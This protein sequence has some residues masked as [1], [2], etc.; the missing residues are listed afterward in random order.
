MPISGNQ[1]ATLAA[2]WVAVI[3]AF[4]AL[5]DYNPAKTTA[6]YSMFQDIHV[7]IF[8]GFGFLMSF[9]VQGSFTSTGHSLLVAMFA[10]VFNIINQWVW[11]RVINGS[12]ASGFSI[13]V[14]SLVDADFAAG[15]VLI[16]FG[17]LIGRVSL[18][19]LVVMAAVEVVFYNINAAVCYGRLAVA[20]IGGSMVIHTFGAYFGLTVSLMLDRTTSRKEKRA[21]KWSSDHNSD[22][23]AMIGTLFLWC[24]WPSFNAYFAGIVENGGV[25]ER[26]VVNTYLS[27]CGSVAATFIASAYFGN[28]KL[29]IVDVQNATL[30]GGVAIGA[31]S[32]MLTMPGGALIVGTVAG[33]LSTF[34]Y[35]VLQP[36]LERKIGLADTCGVHNLHG[37][38]GLLGAFVSIIMS[39]QAD[40]SSYTKSG[41]SWTTVWPDA[42]R[43][44]YTSMALVGL[45]FSS[46]FMTVGLAVGGGVVAAF[47]LR[48]V[49]DL[50]VFYQDSDEYVVEEGHE[51][52]AHGDEEMTKRIESNSE[53]PRGEHNA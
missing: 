1:I 3:V 13:G 31:A 25:G 2:I 49:P 51:E 43:N 14:D 32:N 29:S 22:T 40:S 21:S 53:S 7:M 4:L 38:P 47:I 34:G 33:T 39:S 20:D 17:A 45:Q 50:D 16:S 44:S 42:D 26:V 24:F 48:F 5:G 18:F 23:L 27:L 28:G 36:K 30:A 52:E 10:A 6:D 37:M 41:Y 12:S 19:Q 15:A 9:L 46:L 8:I 35:N 11:A